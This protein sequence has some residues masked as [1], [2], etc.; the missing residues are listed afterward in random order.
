MAH[1][2]VVEEFSL[3]ERAVLERYFTDV[4]G[5]VFALTNL[6]E[7]VKGALFA[8]YSRTPKSLRRL[9]LDE[10]YR[11]E[12]LPE[13]AA[14]GAEKAAELYDR[15]FIEYGDDSVAQLG[16]AHIAV[17]QASNLLTKILERGR[18]A[19]YLEQSTRYIAY[20]DKPGGR[21]RYYKDPDIARSEHGEAYEETLD[22]IFSI[23]SSLIAPT[24]D[25]FGKEFP[26]DPNDPDRV[27][28]ATIKAK[29]LDAL[30][31]MLP[32]ATVSNVGIYASGQSYEQM[33]LKM[34][35]DPL[36]E[37]RET[38]SKM[39]AQLRT[40]IPAF[41][42]RVDQP[43]RGGVWSEY[44][45]NTKNRM[46]DLSE[47]LLG[48]LDG[49]EKPAGV[50]TVSLTDW[51]PD[52]EEK[53]V[54]AMLYDSSDL[55]DDRLL[56]IAKK[57]SAEDRMR[58]V[59]AYVGDRQNRRHRP[60]RGLERIDYRF[61]VLSDYAAFR[62]LQRHRML[63]IQ[64]QALSARHGYDRPPE[65]DEAGFGKAFD[66]AM[67]QSAQLWDRLYPILPDQ[68]QY[69]VCMAYKIRYVM[70]MNARE[71]MHLIELRSSPQGHRSYRAIAQEMHR[72]I[73][74]VAGHKTVAGFMRYVDFSNVDLERLEA[75]RRA[76]RKRQSAGEPR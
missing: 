37:A 56:E 38:A 49:D 42:V 39:L 67:A 70:Q 35:S 20:D 62:D 11:G 14:A 59:R 31:G 47:E 28:K 10:F 18:L 66:E 24:Y 30:R 29:V 45:A 63:T 68:S 52:A 3:E 23:Y 55:P 27:Y 5:P 60:G 32:A 33:L 69:A 53:L 41:L 26:Q 6:P 51:D 76:E 75:E 71:A 1:P 17:E 65:A 54:A 57:M 9:F 12:P 8:R 7:V 46:R 61:D 34:Q 15:I 4:E 16:G 50:P 2:Y 44:F 21:W 58:V 36:A 25:W 43:D 48:G 19:G 22:S 40:V 13:G 73:A 64:W 74:D 72:L